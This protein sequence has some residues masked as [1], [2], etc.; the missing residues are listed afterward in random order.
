MNSRR[1]Q[2]DVSA[3]GSARLGLKGSPSPMNKLKLQSRHSSRKSSVRKSY[4]EKKQLRVQT[5]S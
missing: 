3:L 5:G 2:E 4:G 1:S